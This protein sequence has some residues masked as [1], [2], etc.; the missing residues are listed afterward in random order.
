MASLESGG[1]TPRSA[2]RASAVPAYDRKNASQPRKIQR[3]MTAVKPDKSG[4]LRVSTWNVGSLT[5]KSGEVARELSSRKVDIACLQ[6]TRWR[7]QGTRKIGEG[8]KLFWSGGERSA[9]W[10]WNSHHQQA[11]K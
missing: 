3:V 10:G 2:A 5:G 7:G 4:T 11:D 6:E 9:E 8:M 1:R